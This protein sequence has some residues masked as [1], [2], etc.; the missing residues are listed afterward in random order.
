MKRFFRSWLLWNFSFIS[1]AILQFFLYLFLLPLSLFKPLHF[2][3]RKKKPLLL[4]HGYCHFSWVWIYHFWNLK[5]RYGPIYTLNLG[6]P[7]ASIKTYAEKLEKILSLEKNWVLIGHSMGGLVAVHAAC[8]KYKARI[9]KIITLSTPFSGTKMASWGIGLCCREMKIGSFFLQEMKEKM[10]FLHCPIY[11]I[12]TRQDRIVIPHESALL[13]GGKE[14][15]GIGH[16]GL[17][18]YREVLK[19]LFLWIN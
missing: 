15:E 18:F 2:S 16:V 7:F 8:G 10:R 9:E 19:Q 3:K 1:D 14:F 5:K 12:A 17:L 13:P 11:S 4:V 6:N